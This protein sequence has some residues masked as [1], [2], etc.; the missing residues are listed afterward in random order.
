MATRRQQSARDDPRRDL[1][2]AAWAHEREAELTRLRRRR[3]RD[4]RFRAYAVGAVFLASAFL[5]FFLSDLVMKGWPALQQAEILTEVRF[6]P[7]ILDDIGVAFPEPVRDLVSRAAKRSIAQEAEIAE[8]RVPVQLDAAAKAPRTAVQPLSIT[9]AD[10]PPWERDFEPTTIPRKQLLTL[11]GERGL[12][13][14]RTRLI[15]SPATPEG[16]TSASGSVAMWL[17]GSP[18][19]QRFMRGQGRLPESLHE[20]A[21]LLE[22]AGQ[23]RMGFDHAAFGP[24]GKTLRRWVLADADVDQYLKGYDY[25][26]PGN[27][28]KP[29]RAPI[30]R[31]TA[32]RIERLHAAGRIELRFND[33]FFLRGDSKIPEAAG[34]RAA[35]IGSVYV[36]GLVF[37]VVLPL[38]V[39]TSIYLEEYAPDNLLTQTIE[40]NI[41]NLAAIPSILFGVLGLA[42]FIN[43]FG[44][45]RS[46]VMVGTAVLVLMTL[47]VVIIASRAALRAV[48]DS[49]RY[50]GYAMGAS[51]WQVVQHHVLPLSISGI[52]TGSIIG[53]AQAMGETA[54][55]LIV[56]LVSFVPEGP[57]TPLDPTTVMPAQIFSWWSMSLRAFQE[58]AALAILVLLLVLFTLNGLAVLIRA[59]SERKW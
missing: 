41:N 21:A 33:E 17:V 30:S 18:K 44:M 40:V 22:R 2:G 50:A 51:R 59:R 32:E 9:Q 16:A 1:A 36:V 45:P 3:R 37:L 53:I 10:M 24:D 52:M 35:I 39:L 34:M 11:V 23:V 58:R 28:A 6:E 47:P 31:E 46:S 5:L 48:P 56:G 54:P 20:T 7:D 49:I 25:M 55:L 13:Q 57:T 4:Q 26:R 14:I 12:D 42:A 8:I 43:F 15:E 27:Y 38:G 19:L 29:D